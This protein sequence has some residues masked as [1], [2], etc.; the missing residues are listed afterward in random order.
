M[1][2]CKKLSELRKKSGLSQEKLAE[3]VGVSRQAVTKWESG[4]S[5]PDTENLVRLAEIF[6]VSIDELCTGEEPKPKAKIHPASHILA[7]ASVLIVAAYCF[8]GAAAKIF[9]GETLI[10][11]LIMAFPMHVFL[12]LVFW[13]MVRT[14]EF[15]MLAGYDSSI[16][17]NTEAL[18]RYLAGLDFFLGFT[19]ASYILLMAATSLIVP[20]FEII[21]ILLVG[22]VLSFVAGILFMGYK[23][24][25]GVYEDPKDAENAKRAMPSS[26]ILLAGILLSVGAF[27][28]A[29]ELKGYRNNTLEP[30]PMLGMMF[31]SVILALAGYLAEQNRIKKCDEHTPFF[32]K[33]FIVLNILALLCMVLMAF[34]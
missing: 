14:G 9:S 31:L 18:K 2:F 20:Q 5:N 27:V 29:F 11:L 10:A 30:F 3:L 12:H 7:F 33:T 8:I 23:Y 16:K 32:G 28:L 21:P 34:L 1:E 4:K 19:S 24:S 26:I 17:Y 15:S 13:G 25:D 6:G 22:Y